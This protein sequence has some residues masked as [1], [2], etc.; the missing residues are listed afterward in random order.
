MAATG[1]NCNCKWSEV[2][3]WTATASTANNCKILRCCGVQRLQDEIPFHQAVA[4]LAGLDISAYAHAQTHAYDIFWPS[5]D[6]C[7]LTKN[8]ERQ[9][10]VSS[11]SRLLLLYPKDNSF[12]SKKRQELWLQWQRILERYQSNQA[13][14]PWFIFSRLWKE[15]SPHVLLMPNKMRRCGVHVVRSDLFTTA[16]Q[17]YTQYIYIYTII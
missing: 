7:S 12:T 8:M 17:L 3:W 9:N 13:T 5:C 10:L 1:C 16:L 15:S 14:Q 2:I 4:R 6:H 11:S